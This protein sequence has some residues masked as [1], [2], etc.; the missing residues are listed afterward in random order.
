VGIFP[1]LV[2][3]GKRRLYGAAR[4]TASYFRQEREGVLLAGVFFTLAVAIFASSPDAWRPGSDG[5]YSYVYARSLAFDGDIDFE[6]DYAHCGDPFRLGGDRGSGRP[7]NIFYVG[8]AL[9]WTPILLT[10][11][12]L[13]V[14]GNGCG[15]PW[16]VACLSLSLVAGALAVFACYRFVATYFG[17][18]VA[19]ASVGLVVFGGPALL[20]T[21]AAP[22]YSH[23]YDLL[24]SAVLCGLGAR[25]AE[26]SERW[27]LVVLAS[28]TLVALILHRASNLVFAALPLVAVL[29]SFPRG[30]RRL[31]ALFIVSSATFAG[32]AVLSVIAAKLHGG[33]LAFSHG[34]YFL[35]FRQMHP[36]LLL[37]NTEAGVFFFWPTVWFA[38]VGAFLCFRSARL[39]IMAVPLAAI[40][41]FELLSSSA[42]LDWSPAR[43]LLNLA[44]MF[45]LFT[46]ALVDRL[47]GWLSSREGRGLGL[48]SVLGLLPLLVWSTGYAWG[49]S[50]RL[51]AIG[52]P[53][54]QAE[55][56]GGG[57]SAFFAMLDR[58]TGTLPILPAELYYS[59]SRDMP[60]QTFGDAA[61]ARFYRR[62]F[63]TL[64]WVD[65]RIDLAR[66]HA[67]GLT[68]G[69]E[70]SKSPRG[71][72]LVSSHARATFATQWPHVTD[73]VVRV[74]SHT[75]TRFRLGVVR[76]GGTDWLP[77]QPVDGA[78][79]I[80]FDVK[81]LGL[82][83]GMQELAFAAPD[84]SGDVLIESLEFD[85]R[86]PREPIVRALPK[87]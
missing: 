77:E 19:A 26:G 3:D 22:S 30:R 42:A 74:R 73:I 20:F 35:N 38:L 55:L 70:P 62:D 4:R 27:R 45:S 2:A 54:D 68:P 51:V 65:R 66:L 25:V 69:L 32:V 10:M 31:L 87:R 15:P 12:L 85:D 14:D 33:P 47:R 5:H 46:A 6:N 11:R 81:K 56:Y 84:A 23:V 41:F 34:P 57:V 67:E 44:P 59:A 76:L 79:R 9:F 17:R 8:P 21:A 53:L 37:F 1:E 61:S 39:R 18:G 24:L 29:R 75:P 40:G 52:R 16:T 82:G 58:S 28:L 60:R 13:G 64:E 71:M 63:R 49:A 36:F 72:R 78:T 50:H 7:D 86:E 83:S 80:R 48:A 43:R